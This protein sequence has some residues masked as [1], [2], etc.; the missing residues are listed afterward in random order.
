M[1]PWVHRDS[2][3]RSNGAG[4]VYAL[5]RHPEALQYLL[6]EADRDV[7]YV[8]P[9]AG[10]VKALPLRF[11]QPI[12][13]VAS[14]VLHHVDAPERAI[15]A[16]AGGIPRDSLF[17]VI[18]YHPDAPMGRRRNTGSP[19]AACASGFPQEGSLSTRSETSPRECTQCSAVDRGES[20]RA[21]YWYRH[22]LFPEHTFRTQW[23]LN[24]L[25]WYCQVWSTE[26]RGW[27]CL[28]AVPIFRHGRCPKD[29]LGERRT[30]GRSLFPQ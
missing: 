1:W 19:P 17:L 22:V 15:E 10:D 26:D 27:P 24:E 29:E 11:S 21:I 23:L 12:A 25:L 30:H 20:Q 7:G 18:E 5:D 6:E 3:G 13:T 4:I 8:R 2:T 9:M 14:L 28:D 16:V